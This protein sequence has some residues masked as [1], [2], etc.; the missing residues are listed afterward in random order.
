MRYKREHHV[1]FQTPT[2]QHARTDQPR[3][4]RRKK[5]HAKKFDLRFY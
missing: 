4:C 3:I 5:E 1:S 2:L